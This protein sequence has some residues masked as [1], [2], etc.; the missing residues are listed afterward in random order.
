MSDVDDGFMSEDAL[1]LPLAEPSGVGGRSRAGSA[2]D[3]NNHRIVEYQDQGA[4]PAHLG[5][6]RITGPAQFCCGQ[7]CIGI[8]FAATGRRVES[9]QALAPRLQ[10]RRPCAPNCAAQ[11]LVSMRE[12]LFGIHRA[13]LG[14]Q[15][16]TK[17]AQRLADTP[18]LCV[19]HSSQIASDS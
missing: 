17:R 19:P 11:Q 3:T 9:L 16:L 7:S 18:V 15:R 1:S 6:L 10:V 4:T 5:R 14:E 12:R 2:A 8:A 13:L